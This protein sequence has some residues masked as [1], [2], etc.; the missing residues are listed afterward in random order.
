MKLGPSTPVAV[1]ISVWL[2]M[3]ACSIQL[4]GTQERRIIDLNAGPAAARLNVAQQYA[5]AEQLG[6][7]RSLARKQ[8]PGLTDADIATLGLAW[9]KGVFA[10]GEHVMLVVT[11]MPS[12]KSIDAAAVADF[13]ANKVRDDVKAHLQQTPSGAVTLAEPVPSNDKMQLTSHG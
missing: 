2:G 1:T 8:F 3:S 7:L 12:T 9:Q 11:F 4:G 10:D 13:I 6:V 5:T